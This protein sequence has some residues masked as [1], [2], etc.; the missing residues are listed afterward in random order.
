MNG[1]NRVFLGETDT[2]E[3]ALTKADLAFKVGK[4]PLFRLVDGDYVPSTTH[5]ETRRLDTQAALGVVGVDYGVAQQ[6]QSFAALQDVVDAGAGRLVAAGYCDGGAKVWMQAEVSRVDVTAGDAVASLLTVVNSH[7]GSFSWG[8]GYSAVRIVCRNTMMA[9][10]RSIAF[11]ARHTSGIRLAIERFR[12]EV[13]KERTTLETGAELFRH[14]LSKKLSD[15]NLIHY[16]RETLVPGAGSDPNVVV[17]NVDR[18]VELAQTGAGAAP[19][20]LYGGYNA[21]TNW[22]SHERGRSENARQSALLFGQGSALAQRALE[23]ATVYAEKLP[24]NDFGRIALESTATAKA[25]F[26]ALL[27]R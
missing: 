21:V 24:S 6:A 25:E 12:A 11:K 26:D 13:A 15:K 19:G 3:S 17:R 20:T 9:A 1:F 14:L 7:D 8:G 27:A 5:V 22:L 23:V 10:H 16:V 18:V 4:A 2:I